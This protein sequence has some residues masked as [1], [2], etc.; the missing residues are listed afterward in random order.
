MA[1]DPA[2][3]FYPGDWTLGTMAMTRH[4]KG[5][6]ID[7]LMAQFSLGPL[8]LNQIKTLLGPDQAMWTVLQAKFKTTGDGRWFNERLEAEKTKRASYTESR[9]N[10]RKK[11]YEETYDTTHEKHMIHHM[12]NVN[13]N[14][15]EN[16]L[17]GG[18]GEKS[19]NPNDLLDP[20]GDFYMQFQI[21]I[22]NHGLEWNE[23]KKYW[24]QFVAKRISEGT[25]FTRKQMIAKFDVFLGWW[26]DNKKSRAKDES[27]KSNLD[28]LKEQIGMA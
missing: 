3:L 25:L 9:R 13:E 7:L 19:F 15:N 6:Y 12:E 26:S 10:N 4:E 16:D 24:D 28:I 18:V 11:S 8:T 20:S 17:K 22:K 27:K 14:V 2:F 23:S 5:C 21:M 1:K